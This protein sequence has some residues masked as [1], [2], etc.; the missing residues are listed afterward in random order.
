VEQKVDA[1]LRIADRVAFLE[2]G[3]LVHESSATSVAPQMLER[4]VGVRRA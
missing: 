1:A 2:N 4:Y 3:A